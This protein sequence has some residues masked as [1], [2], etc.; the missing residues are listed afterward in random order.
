MLTT[1]F[2]YDFMCDQR[3][4]QFRNQSDSQITKKSK[5]ENPFSLKSVRKTKE[6]LSNC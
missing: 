6:L 3:N 2:A 4:R 5:T 1:T